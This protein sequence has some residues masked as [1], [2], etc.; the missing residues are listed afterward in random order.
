MRKLVFRINT[1]LPANST[2]SRN[3]EISTH[4]GSRVMVKDGIPSVF[5]IADADHTSDALLLEWYRKRY[6]SFGMRIDI[7]HDSNVETIPVVEPKVESVKVEPEKEIA[8]VAS[9]KEDVVE[10]KVEVQIEKTEPEIKPVVNEQ[11]VVS[12]PVVNE[13]PVVEQPV[14]SEQLVVSAPT[15]LNAENNVSEQ[16][17]DN[18]EEQVVAELFNEVPVGASDHTVVETKSVVEP[19]IKV[20]TVSAKVPQNPAETMGYYEMIKF[21]QEKGIEVPDGKSKESYVKA[22][23]DW[24]NSQI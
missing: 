17:S 14:V 23:T 6:A 1:N 16:V 9:V 8:Q 11:P 21:A 12:A 10:S 22:L 3:L 24:Y 13:Q 2:R 4:S 7:I 20:S 19:E 5:P 15:V 18:S